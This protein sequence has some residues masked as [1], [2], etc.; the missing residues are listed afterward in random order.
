M[1]AMIM[2]RGHVIPRRSDVM[3]AALN[4]ALRAAVL[5]LSLPIV[6]RV[7]FQAQLLEERRQGYICFS[8]QGRLVEANRRAHDLVA[9][10]QIAAQIRGRRKAVAAFGERACALTPGDT[11]WVLP[12]SEPGSWLQVTTHRM[13][14]EAYD[15]MEDVLLVVMEEL[16][17]PQ[18][19]SEPPEEHGPFTPAEWKVVRLLLGTGGSH[20]EIAHQLGRSPRTVD[21]HMDHIYKKAGVHSAGE[22]GVWLKQR[23]I[24]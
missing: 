20:K 12:A 19:S 15:L 13:S 2:E 24:T 21:T 9:R 3:L 7:P 8:L 17:V 14:R 18:P 5:R 23:G 10:Y 6:G 22:F 1:L 4:P 16:I 11:P